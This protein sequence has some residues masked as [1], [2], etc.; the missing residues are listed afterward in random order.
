MLRGRTEWYAGEL[1]NIYIPL[2]CDSAILR[3]SSRRKGLITA[4]LDLSTRSSGRLLLM[5]L[6]L[7]QECLPASRSSFSL[8]LSFVT[9]MSSPVPRAPCLPLRSMRAR[10]VVGFSLLPLCVLLFVVFVDTPRGPAGTRS[11]DI[12]EACLMGI[13]GCRNVVGYDDDGTKRSLL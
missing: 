2:H 4:V 1:W 13:V 5:G 10:A 7:G 8:P 9:S 3:H 12:G 6:H 11:P